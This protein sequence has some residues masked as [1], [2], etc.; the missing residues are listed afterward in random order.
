MQSAVRARQHTRSRAEFDRVIQPKC[1]VTNDIE[2]HSMDCGVSVD[3]QTFSHLRANQ[4]AFRCLNNGVCIQTPQKSQCDCS[5]TLYTGVRCQEPAPIMAFNGRQL[6]HFHFPTTQH[7]GVDLIHFSFRT[8]QTH[9]MLLHT[10]AELVRYSAVNFIE[11]IKNTGIPKISLL[12]SRL[13][14]NYSTGFELSLK[15]GQL[16]LRHYSGSNESVS[17]YSLMITNR[18]S[19]KRQFYQWMDTDMLVKC[20]HLYLNDLSILYSKMR[21]T[22]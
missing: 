1:E 20:C 13:Y 12:L 9:V 17:P 14:R 4:T 2:K 21:S 15:S 19:F 6:V 3:D 16:C 5:G 11:Q 22:Y 10:Y 18:I 8:I 7:S